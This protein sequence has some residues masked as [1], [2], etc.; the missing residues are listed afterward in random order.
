MKDRLLFE[1]TILSNGLKVYSQFDPSVDF[2]YFSLWA[3]VG[4]CHNSGAIIPGTFHY[5]EH[6][7]IK[8]SDLYPEKGSAQGTAEK[9]GGKFN[10]TTWLNRTDYNIRI[11]SQYF[12]EMIDAVLAHF[13]NPTF[14]ENSVVEERETISSERKRKG[15]FYP[16]TSQENW[17]VETKW[18]SNCQVPVKQSLGMDDDFL[19]MDADYFHKIHQQFYFTKNNYCIIAG[20]F[21]LDEVCKKLEQAVL[22]DD[23]ILPN[24]SYQPLSWNQKE[25]HEFQTVGISRMNYYLNWVYPI[26]PD[27]ERTHFFINGVVNSMLSDYTIGGIMKWLRYDKGWVYEIKTN[28]TAIKGVINGGLMI[29]LHSMEQVHK[30]RSE[31]KD[32]ILGALT[33]TKLLEKVKLQRKNAAV[34]EYETVESR[35]NKAAND[36]RWY[37]GIATM[38]NQLDTLDGITCDMLEKIFTEHLQPN[39]GEVLIVPNA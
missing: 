12:P 7:V 39:I 21:K 30:V 9:L 11:P 28:R 5:L 10:A 34:F 3:P 2:A 16:A 32:K 1:C 36:L 26:V 19:K 14:D 25:F 18:K 15:P 23:V 24:F 31:I 6:L 17:Y 20:N 8:T 27:A 13:Y 22:V 37:S 29:P 4:S 38:Q 35:M 33:N